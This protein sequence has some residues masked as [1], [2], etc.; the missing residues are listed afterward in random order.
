MAPLSKLTALVVAA[1]LTATSAIAA[2]PDRK[3]PVSGQ[4]IAELYSGTTWT[5]GGSYWGPDGSFQAI[6]EDSVGLG[7][8]YATSKGYLC[9]EAT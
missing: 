8:W 6:W 7:K 5:K 3:K 2:G 1:A 9:Y 4:T